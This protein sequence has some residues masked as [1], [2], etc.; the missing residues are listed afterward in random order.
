MVASKRLNASQVGHGSCRSRRNSKNAALAILLTAVFAVAPLSLFVSPSYAAATPPPVY[1]VSPVGSDTTGN[2]SVGSPF[3]T[4]SHA[5]A[6]A[7]AGTSVIVEPGTYAEMVVVSVQVKLL[8]Q[9]SQ[10][11]NT[12]I[13]ATGKP[14]GIAVVG[15]STAGTVV[16]G[17]TVRN[18]NDE[19]I[20]VQDSSQAVIE[21][22]VVT[23]NALQPFAGVGEAKG[24]QLTGT[25]TSTVADNTVIGNEYGGIGV[26]DV[27]AINPS[28]NVTAA[29]NA[30][31]PAAT[32]NPGNDNMI[33]GNFVVGN[34]PN[35]C[36]IVISAYNTGEGVSDNIVSGNTVVDNQNGVIVAADTPNTIA[37]NNTILS[38]TILNN[39][40]G[41]VVVHSNAPGDVVT[42]NLISGNVFSADGYPPTL[43][44]IIVGGEGP[45]PVQA[46]TI[47]GNTFQNEAIGIQIV[48]A[49]TTY[50]GGNVY[51]A[52]VRLP[53]NG[54]VTNISVSGSGGGSSSSAST[55]TST[56]SQTVTATTTQTVTSTASGTASSS[57]GGLTFSVALLTA[58]GTLIVGLVAGMVVRPIRESAGR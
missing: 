4:I 58:I 20:Y 16:E 55:V 45:V 27:G 40:E 53:V 13:D 42:G 34:R 28:W 23:H 49:K 52:T 44:G 48:N 15:S 31:V 21:N 7:T 12:I 11:S 54:T 10:P 38:N 35:H 51:E 5:V 33:S 17:F 1:Y 37:V 43:E 9:S 39:G 56:V 2:G 22:N 14:N 3:A 57:E 46:T 29:P 26:T 41:G 6:L 19:G 30:G 47:T 32:A 36:A 24:I 50:V 8:S 18:A 25:S